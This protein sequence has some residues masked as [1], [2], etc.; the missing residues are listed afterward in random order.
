MPETGLFCP[1]RRGCVFNNRLQVEIAI[2]KPR[3]SLF[4]ERMSSSLQGSAPDVDSGGCL[5]VYTPLVH[6]FRS[7]LFPPSVPSYFYCRGHSSRSLSFSSLAWG[8]SPYEHVLDLDVKLLGGLPTPLMP[9]C[10][11]HDGRGYVLPAKRNRARLPGGRRSCVGQTT[12]GYA[13]R[14]MHHGICGDPPRSQPRCGR[15]SGRKLGNTKE[16]S[17]RRT[18]Y[19][20]DRKYNKT[21]RRKGWGGKRSIEDYCSPQP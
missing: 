16:A 21:T 9:T 18:R 20:Q 11:S 12:I 3:F 6:L 2:I 15:Q 8:Y 1:T 4:G 17:H 14:S 19:A 7:S 5:L 10:C 13:V